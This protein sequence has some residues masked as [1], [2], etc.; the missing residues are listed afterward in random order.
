MSSRLAKPH[1]V[2]RG[3]Q[4]NMASQRPVWTAERAGGQ[5]ELRS[6]LEGS[7]DCRVSVEPAWVIQ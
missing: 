3:S 1:M 4:G 7:L 5:P 6:K 2:F